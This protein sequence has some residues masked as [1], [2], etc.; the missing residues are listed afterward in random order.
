MDGYRIG[1]LARMAGVSVRTLRFY[2][3]IGLLAPAR[4]ADNGYRVYSSRDVDRLQEILLLRQLG[5]AV[6]DIP[7][8]L[9]ADAGAR[10]RA[11]AG[12]LARLRAE[13][14]R[15]S[16]LIDTVERTITA[17]EGGEP[18]ADAEKFE[19]FKRK[20]VQDNEERCGAEARARYGDAAVDES[21]RRM[22]NMSETEYRRFRAL[23][24]EI[25]TILEEAVRAGAD[26]AGETGAR[27]CALHREWLGFTWPAYS[28][29][30]H[31]GLAE[32]YVADERFRDYYDRDVAGCAAWLRDAILA[33][34]VR[35]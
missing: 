24:D 7:P 32:T 25:R 29:E 20:L 2:D 9:S 22:L 26:P 23:E 4:R 3:E 1:E 8:L 35:Q 19:G 12:H 28:A 16:R 15:L 10:L 27:V 17:R 21:N 13:R 5:V 14:D 11:L 33:H 34:A 6:R 18:M 30:A 31:R